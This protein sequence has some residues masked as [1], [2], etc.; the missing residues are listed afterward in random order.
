VV[1]QLSRGEVAPAI[2]ALNEQGC[3]HEIADREDRLNAIAGE[4]LRQP[5]GTLVVS[6]DN[7]SRM[8]INQVIHR[9]MQREGHVNHVEHGAQRRPGS[10]SRCSAAWPPW[11]PHARRAGRPPL[12][13]ADR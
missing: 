11:T 12:A 13:M 2:H 5:D 1:E 8:E 4:Y 6:P 3:I 9:A 7:Q 10:H